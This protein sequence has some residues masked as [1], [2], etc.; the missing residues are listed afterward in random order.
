METKDKNDQVQVEQL[1]EKDS[2]AQFPES[3]AEKK[4][5]EG[6]DLAGNKTPEPVSNTGTNDM[7]GEPESQ[8]G[9]EKP[10]LEKGESKNVIKKSGKKLDKKEKEPLKERIKKRGDP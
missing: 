9:E 5:N 1:K 3:S 10:A 6:N 8:P 4:Q 2:Q 7:K